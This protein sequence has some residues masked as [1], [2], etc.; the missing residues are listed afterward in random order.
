MVTP[1]L[2]SLSS[3]LLDA[4]AVGEP[5]AVARALTTLHSLVVFG[6]LPPPDRGRVVALAR[7]WLSEGHAP[8]VWLSAVELA[9]AT[10]DEELRAMV[11]AIGAGEAQPSLPRDVDLHLFVRSAARRAL[12]QAGRW[13]TVGS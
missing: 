13:V 9:L 2:A 8:E 12:E 7:R 3:R 5:A 1:A 10:G 6:L 4:A 11:T